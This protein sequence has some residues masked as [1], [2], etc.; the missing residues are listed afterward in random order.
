[1]PLFVC[2]NCH[3]VENTVFGRYW[4]KDMKDLWS[5]DN[6]GQALCSECAP[7]TFKSGKK[8]IYNGKWHGE[9]T[10]GKATKAELQEEGYF[11]YVPK[12]LLEKK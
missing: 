2:D 6:L 5:E 4:S 8:S 10:K 1:M 9:F 7:I 11:I 3:C 12:E